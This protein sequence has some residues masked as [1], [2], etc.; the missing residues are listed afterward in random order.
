MEDGLDVVARDTGFSGVVR[1]DRD[2]QVFAKAYGL[3]HRGYGIANTVDTRF[4]IASGCKGFT[5]LTVVSLMEQGLLTLSTTAREVLGEDLPLIDAAVTVEHLLAHRSGIGDYFDEDVVTDLSAYVL[6]VPVQCL[7]D[8]EQYLPVLDGYPQKFP[9]GE[10]FSYCN[11]GF[12]VLALIAERVSGVPFH[13]LVRQRVCE[14][15]GLVDTDFL[16][17][18]SLGERTAVGYLQVDGEWR[19]NVFHLPI[20]GGGDGGIYTTAADVT[21]LWRALFAGRI[22]SPDRVA[23]MVRPRSDVPAESMRYGLGFWLHETGGAVI[24]IGGDAGVSFK[25]VHVPESGTTHT[26]IAN[27]SEGAWPLVRFL[28]V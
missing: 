6:P 9:P 8:I 22:V 15:A 18:D 24:L 11:S 13:D 21:A 2:G 16:R 17:S 20:R 28:G 10:R 27:T 14:P 3:A 25:S 19:T 26:V 4:A 5:A 7:L 12:V 23:E 1:V